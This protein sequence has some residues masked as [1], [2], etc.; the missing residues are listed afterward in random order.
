LSTSSRKANSS[1]RSSYAFFTLGRA[2]ARVLNCFRVPVMW[3]SQIR[4]ERLHFLG[5]SQ[6]AR[7]Q[8]AWESEDLD[9]DAF[10]VE[11]DVPSHRRSI[12]Y[13]LCRDCRMIGRI[14]ILEPG[15]SRRRV[16]VTCKKEVPISLPS[17]K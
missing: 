3:H 14:P 12:A 2:K 6:K 10:V 11:G 7:K 8:A 9:L 1:A 5:I 13:P 16:S 17:C 4:P 15:P